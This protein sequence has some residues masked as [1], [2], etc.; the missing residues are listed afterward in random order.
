MKKNKILRY[1]VYLIFCALILIMGVTLN[2]YINTIDEF[3][4]EN[5]VDVDNY[6]DNDIVVYGD[7][8]EINWKFENK[9]FEFKENS[10][11]YYDDCSDGDN[12]NDYDNGS[13]INICIL[14]S[15][16]F[17]AFFAGCIFS[18]KYFLKIGTI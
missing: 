18:E 13:L 17:V 15:K 14:F 6:N 9:N 16:F 4:L 8:N 1:F 5:E 3:D 11:D 2:F 7:N 12:D 10:N